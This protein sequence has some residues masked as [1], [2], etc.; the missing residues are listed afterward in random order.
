MKI[1][2]VVLLLNTLQISAQQLN[3][4]PMPVEIQV[5]PGYLTI[6]QPIGFIYNAG[7]EPGDGGVRFFEDLLQKKYGFTK[8]IEGDTHSY[9]LPTEI[10]IDFDKKYEN[11]EYKIEI[12]GKN[13]LIR[14]NANGIFY[15]FQTLAQMIVVDKKKLVKI[16]YAVIKDHPRFKYRGMHLDVSRHFFEVK[17]IKRYIDYLSYHKFNNFH[18]HLTDDQGWRI[19]IKKYPKLTAVGGCRSRTLKGRYGSDI[20]DSTKYCGFYTQTQIKEIVKYAADRYINIIPEID[21]PGHSLVALASYPFLGCTKGPYKVMETW[22]VQPDVMC[23]GNDSTYQFIQNVLDELIS[24]FPSIYIHIGGDESPKDRWKEC[25]VCQQKILKEN[26]KDEHGLQSYFIQRVEKYLHSKGRRII[27]WD[28]ILEGGLAKD[29]TVMSWRGIKGGIA[30]AKQQHDAIM[31]PE[32]P[33]YFNHSQS[34]NEDS[35]T[36]GGYNPLEE[37]YNYEPV[38]EKLNREDAKYILGAQGNA[39]TEYI[40][41]RKKLEY[42][43]FPRMSALSEVLW[44]P[45][46]NRN[47]KDFEKRLPALFKKYRS[48]GAHYS[49]AYYDLQPSVIPLKGISWK[50]ETKNKEGTIIYVQGRERNASFEYTTPLPIVRSATF[51]AALTSKDHTIISS[52]IWQEFLINMASGK[53]IT[54]TQLPNKNYSGS[55]PFTLVDGVQNNEGMIKSAQFLGFLGT[56]LEATIDLEKIQQVNEIILHA[57]E[58]K[59]SWIYRP[60]SVT[61]HVS[62]NGTDF[63]LLDTINEPAGNKNLLYKISTNTKTRFIKI[64]A[65]NLGTIPEGM[66][67]SGSSA[68]LFADEIEVN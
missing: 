57:F 27:G 62:D 46:E 52:W 49:T 22:G 9:G 5:K 15:A 38:P 29:A 50:L 1:L 25:P 32:S 21:M 28:E 23:A 6:T 66:P 31:T 36:Q 63:K 3:I 45:K 10:F 39:W 20:Y 41:S 16:P 7:I 13:I 40:D 35:L 60:A 47:W 37:V 58:Q 2:I 56:D 67:G 61:F 53:K 42:S 4:V 48:W 18:W 24:L 19:E 14:G 51:G 68:W 59:G 17:D 55:G 43:I 65:K 64:S 26:L 30:A 33:L 44:S 8:F 34:R 54:L 11:E 12:S